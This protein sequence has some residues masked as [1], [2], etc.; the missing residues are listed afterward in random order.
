MPGPSVAVVHAS[1]KSRSNALRVAGVR[2]N[3][4]NDSSRNDATMGVL[5]GVADEDDGGF[6][7]TEL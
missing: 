6:Q 1:G 3:T 5:Y 7:D 2:A 4:D